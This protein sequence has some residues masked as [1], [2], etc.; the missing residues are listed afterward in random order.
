MSDALVSRSFAIMKEKLKEDRE[1]TL[2]D[3]L[4][5]LSTEQLY[6]ELYGMSR[7]ELIGDIVESVL[8]E[9]NYSSTEEYEENVKASLELKP[10]SKK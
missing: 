8:D 7:A 2:R 1:A 4:R 6:D 10:W 3:K 9:D 5:K